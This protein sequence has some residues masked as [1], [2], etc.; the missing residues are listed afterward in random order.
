M[1]VDGRYW[2]NED[3]SVYTALDI[4]PEL[5]A[6]QM[7]LLVDAVA[8]TGVPEDSPY[9]T[10][11]REHY[12]G[13]EFQIGLTD[14]VRSLAVGGLDAE[15]A[16]QW[17]WFLQAEGDPLPAE[18]VACREAIASLDQAARGW[19]H[20]L[21]IEFIDGTW[22]FPLRAFEADLA[23][24]IETASV[25]ELFVDASGSSPEIVLRLT[26]ES[27]LRRLEVLVDDKRYTDKEPELMFAIAMRPDDSVGPPPDVPDPASLLT[28]RGSYLAAIGVCGELPWIYS[29]FAAGDNYYG[30]GSGGY[31]GPLV[32]A[33]GWYC[34]DEVP[35]SRRTE[36]R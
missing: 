32:F 22:A 14:L 34:E 28:L 36:D 12:R 7:S 11:L 25:C 10:S 29:N 5:I 35:E 17:S 13:D 4:D 24:E 30:P 8:G 3:G 9:L 2:V 19:I 15:W 27:D 23:P 20:D 18:M 21:P 31:E 26:I 1:A 33:S 16:E 6:G